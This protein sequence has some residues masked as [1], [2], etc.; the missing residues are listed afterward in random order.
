[1]FGKSRALALAVAT[2]G[3]IGFAA[4]MASA[5]TVGTG[6]GDNGG[7]VNVSHVQV[8]VQVC[9]NNVPVNVI[10]GQLPV[11]GL[12]GSIGL[13]S[14]GS[15]TTA[16]QDKSCHLK[17]KQDNNAYLPGCTTCGGGGAVVPAS[18]SGGLVNV[19]HVQVPVQVCNN[20]IPVN[21]IGLQVPL[22]DISAALGL[23]NQMSKTTSNQDSSCHLKN[24]QQ[25]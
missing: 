3:V 8:P 14:P 10:G 20:N 15:T 18:D 22:S 17:N 23:G 11:D 13:F 5:A 6:P 9:G 7:L 25:G 16:N 21:V 19:S 1:M 12:A 24:G 4:P 2:A